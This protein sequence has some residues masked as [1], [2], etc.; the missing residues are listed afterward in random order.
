MEVICG[1][2][3]GRDKS[4]NSVSV[5]RMRVMEVI[6]KMDGNKVMRVLQVIGVL[7]VMGVIAKDL[8]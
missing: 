8:N 1:E 2:S 4:D 3:R 5:R 6:F 7:E